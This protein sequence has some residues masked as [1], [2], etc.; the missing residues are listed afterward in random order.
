MNTDDTSTYVYDLDE[1]AASIDELRA[2]LPTQS[3]LL[4]SIKANPHPY[5]VEHAARHG[6]GLEV[7]SEGEL[8]IASAA[9]V[10]ANTDAEIVCTGPGKTTDYLE[11]AVEKG[12]VISIESPTELTR[13]RELGSTGQNVLV[14]INATAT[15]Q[16]SG[17]QMTGTASPFGVD[18][19][20]ADTVVRRVIDDGHN[21][22]GVHLYMGSNILSEDDLV[23]QFEISTR[24]A[25]HYVDY[26]SGT[27]IADL[28]GGF[29]HPFAAPGPR[30]RWQGLRRRV[31]SL[32]E[33]LSARRAL[34]TFESGRYIAGSCGTLSA[35][36][37]D[38]KQSKGQRFVVLSSGVNH[39]G[40]LSGLR[41]LPRTRVAPTPYEH[42]G[43]TPESL[44]GPLCTPV[45]VLNKQSPTNLEVGDTVTIPNVGAYGLSASL[46]N[47]LSHPYPT[48]HIRFGGRLI[49][50]TRSQ[51]TYQ[52][53]VPT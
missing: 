6:A 37:L 52:E 17:L 20:D 8:A 11:S 9:R 42:G 24:I 30:P 38:V 14:R 36:V 5:I 2:H 50:T 41:R 26:G 43:G 39:L 47:F 18:E 16:R 49:A 31:E 34:V 21:F 51:I 29:G 15:S 13:L 48:E 27:F 4:Y 40:G 53:V 7:S 10:R 45:D 3:A 35:T 19:Q 28:G 22:R 46:A 1:L 32:T 23:D 25:D 33:R 12:A 44:V